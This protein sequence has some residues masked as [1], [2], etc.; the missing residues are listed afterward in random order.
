MALYVNLIFKIILTQNA[1]EVKDTLDKEI[2]FYLAHV[3]LHM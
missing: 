3:I 1:L 2:N